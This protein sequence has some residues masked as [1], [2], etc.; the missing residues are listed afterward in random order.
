MLI[1]PT[2]NKW[3]CDWQNSSYVK[4]HAVLIHPN[5]VCSL[6]RWKRKDIVHYRKRLLLEFLK[7]WQDNHLHLPRSGLCWHQTNKS[8]TD[9]TYHFRQTLDIGTSK[10]QNHMVPVSKSKGVFHV[11]FFNSLKMHTSLESIKKLCGYPAG[12]MFCF[13]TT[14]E[15]S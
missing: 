14:T 1:Q 4:G 5:L 7:F 9:C 3:N 10:I 2:L 13:K 12:H 11:Q 6:H 8:T 15:Q